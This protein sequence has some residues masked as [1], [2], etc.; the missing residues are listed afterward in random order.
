MSDLRDRIARGE[1]LLG[2]LVPVQGLPAGAENGL[3]LL[4]VR[5]N[6]PASAFVATGL[7]V[8]ILVE[9]SGDLSGG[10]VTVARE[11]GIGADLVLSDYGA[12]RLVSS[13]AAAHT[14]FA[15]G[16][17]LVV[18]D[19][20]A[21]MT[22]AFAGLAEPRPEHSEASAREPLVLLSGMLGDEKLWD[23]V[24]AGIADIALPWPVR[25]DLDDSVPEMAL[26]VL[27][28][29]PPQFAL[30]GH[31]LGA[32]V[33]LEIVRRAP[34]R[35]T[36]LALLNASGRGPSAEQLASWAQARSRTERGEFDEV[37]AELAGATLGAAHRDADLLARNARMALTVGPDGF[38]RQLS[39]QTTRPESRPSLADIDVP[40]LVVSGEDDTIC[41][42]GL[43]RELVEHCGR[44]ELATVPECG[45]MAPLEDPAAVIDVLRR[46]L[47]ES[48]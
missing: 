37:A 22:T 45:H 32:I 35:V 5:P 44:A 3:D 4:V 48:A 41:P 25:I 43:Q 8:A 2:L 42:P 9:S 6:A 27:A 33:A 17:Q 11:P 29:A 14:A 46:W 21:M 47:R 7:P 31:S 28:A 15:T 13:P 38:L 18:Y 10:A 34:E 24:S 39:A 40:V 1:K 16:A 30:A 26:S 19:G 36:R 20:E 12:A 23:D